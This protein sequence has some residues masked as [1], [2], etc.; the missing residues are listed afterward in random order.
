MG[1]HI[2]RLHR[3]LLKIFNALLPLAMNCRRIVAAALF[4]CSPFLIKAQE[5]LPIKFGKVSPAD[6]TLPGN[7]ID[8]GAAAVIVADVGDSYFEGNSKGWFSLVFKRQV[9]IKIVNKNGFEAATESIPLYTAG[10]REE[11]L[12]NL[13]AVTYNL[14]DGKVVETRLDNSSI[15]KEQVN[16]HI[17][18]KKFTLPAVKEGSLI[19]YSYTLN[20]DFLFNL[21]PWSFQGEYPRLW[22]EYHVQIPEFFNYVYLAQG[23]QTPIVNESTDY[24][25]FSVTEQ[26]EGASGSS[27]HYTFSGGVVNKRWVMKNVPALKEEPYTSTLDNHIS[28]VEFQL[29]QYRFPNTPVKDIMGNWFTVSDE[30]MKS[31]DFGLPLGKINN[32]LDDDIKA[33][34]GSASTDLEKAKKIYAFVRDNFT[35]TN[36]NAQV[37]GNTL[38]VIFKNRNGSVADINLL[39]VAMLRHENIKADPVLLSTREHGFAHE[40]YPLMDRYNY[41]I[42]SV[43]LADKEYYLD[44]SQPQLGFAKLPLNCYNGPARVIN[45]QPRVVYFMADSLEE[46]KVT[47]VFIVNNEKKQLDG[48]FQSQ[49][50]LQESS[51]VR[52]VVKNKGMTEFAKTIKSSYGSDY[53]LGTPEID[54]LKILEEP[55]MLHYTFTLD[56]LNED[57]IYFNPIMTEGYKENLFKAA[58]RFYPVEMPFTINETFV[59]NMEIPNGYEV[60]EMPKSAKVSFN[61][62]EGMFEY[63]IAKTATTVQ[64][65]S[66]VILKKANFEP[67]EYNSL[68]DFFGY[69]VKKHS[70][71]IVFKKKK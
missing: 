46:R 29:S 48:S 11:K 15:F 41:V 38:R 55:V 40:F 14:E 16:K 60:D 3:I 65:R 39:L 2:Y 34:E 64:L 30:K 31:E 61:D 4:A 42:A 43:V 51:K 27:Q 24:K 71:Q 47:S 58:E 13:K 18:R 44:A 12:E 32:W 63:V 22:S 57:L 70:E 21:Q 9:R 5:K 25:S 8:S 52:S 20:S 6:F 45:P 7:H 35:C 1:L 17:V 36:H 53:T 49:L 23:Y 19:E 33:I 67:D 69:I 66:R 62:N 54:S 50:G 28:K 68:R 37:M 10:D 56:N 26:G 59:F